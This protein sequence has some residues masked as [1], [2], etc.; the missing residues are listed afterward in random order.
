MELRVTM[1]DWSYSV[2]N[3]SSQSSLA[4]HMVCVQE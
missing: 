2:R 4:N 1:N 3:L